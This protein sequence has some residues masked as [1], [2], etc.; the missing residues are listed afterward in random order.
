M[1]TDVWTVAWKEWKDFISQRG[2]LVGVLFFVVI[3]GIFIPFQ[4]GRAWV[5]SVGGIFNLVLVPIFL[6]LNVIAD[7]FAGE[8]ERHTLETLLAGRLSDAAILFGKILSGVAY[9]WGLTLMGMV[10][11]LTTVNLTAGGSGLLL[12]PARVGIGSVVFS[13]LGVWLVAVV[14]V[15]VSLRAATV[16]QAQ[17]TLSIGIMAIASLALLGFAALPGG[18]RRPIVDFM[19][20]AGLTRVV[21]GAG[22]LLVALD[23]AVLLLVMARFRRSRLILN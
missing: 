23:I 19:R 5:D 1:I 10:L 9:G 22:L 16:R 15:L 17:Q 6:V 2:S 4:S 21:L 14:G 8:R 11:G 3:F 18:I 12:F 20:D 7:A 13:L